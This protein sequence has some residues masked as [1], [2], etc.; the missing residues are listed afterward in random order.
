MSFYGLGS[1]VYRFRWFVLAF[2]AL[3][4]LVGAFFAPRLG[5]ELKGGG[6]DGA[7]T[8][9]ERV[10]EIM[11]DDFSVSPATLTVVFD[12][13]GAPATSERFRRAIGVWAGFHA[14]PEG[15]PM[16]AEEWERRRDEFLTSEADRAYVKSLMVQVT[17]PGKVAGWI[18]PPDRGIN[19][20]PVSYEYV[21][22]A[23]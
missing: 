18:A 6:F 4:L 11:V 3:V 5:D 20:L 14:T 1:F 13:Q 22:L 17:E 2:W 23:A 7:N 21:H 9:A 10:Q 12:G 19:N 16:A 15:T 8:E